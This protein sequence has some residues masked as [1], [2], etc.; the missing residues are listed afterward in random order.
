MA[1][2]AGITLRDTQ[3]PVTFP[4][5]G[6]DR[7]L[8]GHVLRLLDEGAPRGQRSEALWQVAHAAFAA[9]WSDRDLL[10][11]L[12][13]SPLWAHYTAR[14]GRDGL[15]DPLPRAEADVARMRRKRE[16]GARAGGTRD[17][18]DVERLDAIRQAVH[19]WSPPAVPGSRP[20]TLQAVL[21]A[22]IELACRAGSTRHVA[23]SVRDVAEVAA[24]GSRT[25]ARALHGLTILGVL[26]RVSRATG[27]YAA[28]WTL[29][30]DHPALSVSSVSPGVPAATQSPH[31]LQACASVSL[32]VHP[33]TQ[34]VCAGQSCSE[35]VSQP[36][37][38][39]DRHTAGTPL[40][41]RHDAWRHRALGGSA[42][43]A[44]QLLGDGPRAARELGALMGYRR[45]TTV[46]RHLARLEAA[47]LAERCAAGW[48]RTAGDPARLLDAVAVEHGTAGAADRQRQEHARERA[49]WEL[50]LQVAEERARETRSTGW[51]P[52]P[53]EYVPPPGD[54]D[55]PPP[56]PELDHVPAPVDAVLAAA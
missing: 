44:W 10:D 49:G 39:Q 7:V 41:V 52:A 13:A 4:D 37:V 31:R 33:G 14:N 42:H 16:E 12:R 28:R 22:V 17:P 35:S 53:D 19:A 45:R 2:P 25:A 15:R 6:T 8:H 54:A 11:A 21:A 32:R 40:T 1:N 3:T 48:R 23:L 56:D 38:S 43:L 46:Y 55:A 50:R 18:E 24:V 5:G 51:E 47:G 27:T 36:C 20:S 9:G 30:L 34:G 29:Q 26:R